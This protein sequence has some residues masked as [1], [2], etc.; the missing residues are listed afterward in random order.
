ME[1]GWGFS[2][3]EATAAVQAEVV[4][5]YVGFLSLLFFLLLFSVDDVGG[6]ENEKEDHG[7][8]EEVG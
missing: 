3:F 4:F 7:W 6:Q 5:F 8:K 1:I 2:G